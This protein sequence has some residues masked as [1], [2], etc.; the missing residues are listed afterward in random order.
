[1]RSPTSTAVKVCGITS[2]EQ[3]IAIAKLG[4]DAIGVI[5]IQNSKRYVE[6]EKRRKIFSSL[7][8]FEPSILRVL[9][10]ANPNSSMI[11][12]NLQGEGTPS[13]IQL[14]GDENEEQC[15][16][17]KQQHPN[18]QFWKALRIKGTKDIE[19]ANRFVGNVDSL[20]LDSWSPNLLGGTGKRLPLKWLKENPINM[21]WLLAGGID[22]ECVA[23]ILEQIKPWGL[24]ASSQLEDL[25]GIKNLKKV[26]SLI[27]A[28]RDQS[29]SL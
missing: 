6:F 12:S 28:V 11:A 26:K 13:V 5:G 16:R 4:V 22:S 9:V 15:K 23:E 20:L 19:L 17:L 1:M 2:S 25:P 21:Q 18:I 3:A 14:H 10:V 7:I 24:D 29:S 8:N 27:Q